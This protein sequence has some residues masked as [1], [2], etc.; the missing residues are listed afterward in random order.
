M[1][2]SEIEKQ[3]INTAGVVEAGT[4]PAEDVV[5]AE[6]P[7]EDLL[8]LSEKD[9]EEQLQEVEGLLSKAESYEVA[10]LGGS[11]IFTADVNAQ[12]AGGAAASGGACLLYTSPS[13]RDRTRSRMP[14]SA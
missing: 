6:Q 14:S 1:R 5:T 2:D 10:A 4:L 9:K 7:V 8:L 11:P 12:S 13:P 3:I